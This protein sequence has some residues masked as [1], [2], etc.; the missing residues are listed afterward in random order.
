MKKLVAFIIVVMIVCC[1]YASS[2]NESGFSLSEINDYQKKYVGEEMELC[3]SSSSK[4]YMDYRSINLRESTQYKYIQKYMTVDKTTGLLVDNEGFIGV[5]LGS[6]FGDIGDR[7][8]FTLET[9]IVLPVVIIDQ[10]SDSHT[11]NGC[12]HRNDNSVLEFVIDSDVA[13]RF[14]GRYGNGYILQGNFNNYS[15]FKGE[16]AKVE[17]V[18]NIKNKNYVTYSK[19]YEV[20]HNEDIF[21][22][23]SGY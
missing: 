19:G 21:Q 3:S 1:G 7:F 22:Y 14:F 12:Y 13:S 6:Y 17:K 18:T 16:I 15:L 2:L 10:K 11:Y 4:T 5:A 8:Y 9:G 20:N 23:A